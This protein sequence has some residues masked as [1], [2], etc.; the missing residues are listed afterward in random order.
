M[1]KIEY[2][3]DSVEMEPGPN[4][5]FMGNPT[6]YLKLLNDLHGLAAKN[7]VEI[8]LADLD[9]VKLPDGFTYVARSSEN[10]ALLS[11]VEGTQIT[12]DL[13]RELW[14]QVLTWILYIT[15]G[16]GHQ[17]IEFD[18]FDYFKKFDIREDA[19]VIMSSAW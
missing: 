9:Y 7:G 4:I 13:D 17:Y 15:F 8:N 12:M 6:D 1:I 3:L 16:K 18:D 19:N 5:Y 14:K 11:K 2:T 10:G